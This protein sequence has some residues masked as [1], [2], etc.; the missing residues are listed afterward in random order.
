MPSR[1]PWTRFSTKK[2][3]NNMKVTVK[4]PADFTPK[5]WKNGLGIT[6]EIHIHPEGATVEKGDFLWRISSADVTAGGPFSPYPGFDRILFLLTG[7][8]LDLELRGMKVSLAAPFSSVRFRGEDDVM[9]SLPGGPCTDL[10]IISSR[11]AVSCEYRRFT[12]R[13]GGRRLFLLG[14]QTALL[15]LRGAVRARWEG[16]EASLEE[17]GLLLLE[18]YPCN[19]PLWCSP[20]GEGEVLLV[21]ITERP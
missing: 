3:K 8:G 10:N 20:E 12:V 11:D 6:R 9:C 17:L 18:D 14:G 2:R 19:F 5:P 4:R 13:A 1:P 7:G 16:G 15:C 21:T